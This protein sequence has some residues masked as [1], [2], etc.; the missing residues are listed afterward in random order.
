MNTPSI[1]VVDDEPDNFDVI[2]TLLPNLGYKLYYASN[3]QDAIASLDLF[4]PDVILLDVMM[5]GIDGIEVCKRIKAMPQWESVPIIMVT[6]LTTKT[7][8]A[9]CFAA[10]ADDFISKPINH[11]ELKARV[12]SM[13]RI[14]GQYQQLVSFNAQLEATVQQRTAQLETMIL[15]DAL[16][17]LPSRTFLLQKLAEIL[18]AGELSFAVVYL[19]CDQFKLVNG[20]F[21]YAVGNQLLLAMTERLQHHLR[22]GDVLARMGE[23]EFC[24]LL[25][26]IDGAV[27]L[28][29]FIEAVLRGFDASFLVADCEI[30]MTACMGIA[31]G[32]S[33]Y[34]QPE[35][36]LQDADTAM[37]KAKLSGKGC[38]QIFDCQMSLA[39]LNRLTLENDLQRAL[40]HQEFV[41]YYQPIVNLQTQKM[42]GF[43]ALVRWQNPVRGMVLPGEFIPC[44][45]Q[46]GLIVPVGMVVLKQACQQLRIWEQRGWTELTMSVN[47][48]VR[49][50]SS[51]TLLA[52]VDRVLAETAVNPAN[53]KLEITESA[54]IENAQMA[55]AL[56]EQLRSR[57]IQISI[58]DFGTG[59]SSLG[60]LHRF[61]VDNLKIDRSFVNQ[62]QAENRNYQVVNTIITLSNQLE[63]TVIAEG[64]E[65]TQQLQWLQQLGCEFGQGYLFSKPLPATEIERIY[66]TN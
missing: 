33:V 6:A 2:E 10:G 59:Y 61:P 11:L 39:M 20:S 41:I 8:L 50:F 16:T 15:Q 43:E 54:I 36:P 13:L 29:L 38:Y 25:Y 52:D 12:R 1:L 30:F 37:Y 18:Q 22:P 17:A 40:E 7:D 23:D 9:R 64:I 60:Y 19:D 57:Q 53:I 4:K 31:L 62:L 35:E 34:K 65:T 44:M 48:S 66:L 26:N 47:L 42:V 27:D 49:Q 46:T 28:E 14:H 32:S 58:D 63:L 56:T 21:G 45:E 55:I 5:P 24:F 51:P 3:G